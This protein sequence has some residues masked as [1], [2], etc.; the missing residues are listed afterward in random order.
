M[1]IKSFT[2][3]TRRSACGR[4]AGEFT[5][6]QPAKLEGKTMNVPL[7]GNPKN[8]YSFLIQ[9]SGRAGSPLPAANTG[10][11]RARS[12]TPHRTRT[13]PNQAALVTGSGT[14]LSSDG[15]A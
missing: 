13:L 5:L 2:F 1:A 3:Q 4:I 11:R 12:D 6:K 8:K 9:K 10:E 15:N 7:D 14:M